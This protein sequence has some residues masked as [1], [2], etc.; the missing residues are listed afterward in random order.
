M[1]LKKGLTNVLKLPELLKKTDFNKR[2]RQ[3]GNANGLNN[4]R[5][6]RL[7]SRLRLRLRGF[8]L[9][10]PSRLELNKREWPGRSK[11]WNAFKRKSKPRLST[12]DSSWQKLQLKHRLELLL[13]RP[14]SWSNRG[15][16]W[17]VSRPRPLNRLK[18]SKKDLSGK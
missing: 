7:E 3:L 5:I 14:H 11:K 6:W 10:L 17:S 8:W 9:K 16:R 1:K 18:S 12:R 15:S 2:Q 13:N 4:R